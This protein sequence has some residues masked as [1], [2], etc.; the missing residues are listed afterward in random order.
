MFIVIR[1]ISAATSF[2]LMINDIAH[3]VV[4]IS[5]LLGLMTA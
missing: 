3:A 2:L 1:W 5:A 4:R